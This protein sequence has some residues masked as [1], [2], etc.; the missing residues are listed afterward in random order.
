MYEDAFWRPDFDSVQSSV[1]STAPVA[2]P[3]GSKLNPQLYEQDFMR[4]NFTGVEGDVQSTAARPARPWR[5]YA[6]DR[7]LQSGATSLDMI[8]GLTRLTEKSIK[9]PGRLA[10]LLASGKFDKSKP[11]DEQLMLAA[12]ED[13][14]WDAFA[15]TASEYATNARSWL[16]PQEQR[17]TREQSEAIEQGVGPLIDFVAENPQRV[18]ELVLDNVGYF[19]AGG[20]TAATMRAL[21]AGATLATGGAYATE[22]ALAA[23]AAADQARQQIEQI[24]EEALEQKAPDYKRLR[25]EYGAYQARRILSERAADAASGVAA[26]LNAV[27]LGAT[28]RL[29]TLERYAAGALKPAKTVTGGV[30]KGGIGEFVQEGAQGAGDQFAG[31]AAQSTVFPDTDLT[32]GVGASALLEGLVGAGPGAIAGGLSVIADGKPRYTRPGAVQAAQRR[33]GGA[34]VPTPVVETADPAVNAGASVVSDA[35]NRANGAVA[36][37][38]STAAAPARPPGVSDSATPDAAATIQPETAADI[39][40]LEPLSNRRQRRKAAAQAT[41]PVVNIPLPNVNFDSI[42]DQDERETEIVLA[43]AARNRYIS[44]LQT[45]AEQGRPLT[46]DLVAST[47]ESVAAEIGVDPAILATPETIDA[48]SQRTVTRPEVTPSTQPTGAQQDAVA[49]AQQVAETDAGQRGVSERAG[50]ASVP[51]GDRVAEVAA[52]GVDGQPEAVGLRPD[53]REAVGERPVPPAAPEADVQP[54]SAA[55]APVAASAQDRISALTTEQVIDAIENSELRRQK[56]YKRASIAETRRLLALEPP[57]V[58]ERVLSVVQQGTGQATGE[59]AD[60]TIEDVESKALWDAYRQSTESRLNPWQ[61]KNVIEK[62]ASGEKLKS[63]EQQ[64]IDFA[65]QFTGKGPATQTTGTPKFSRRV[66]EQAQSTR[67]RRL[68]AVRIA[69]PQGDMAKRLIPVTAVVAG[70]KQRVSVAADRVLDYAQKRI[71]NLRSLFDCVS[72]P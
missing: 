41:Q 49:E 71:D 54:A 53:D 60:V 13:S 27:T 16:S 2:K 20:G 65:R 35:I 22:V 30:V 6:K 3:V 24:P 7:A 26:V 43:T 59:T 4:P 70:K 64:F 32:K 8:S 56:R 23:S 12:K 40:Q 52:E 10:S 42:E 48:I 46:P 58:L 9:T 17:I 69:V 11:L 63:K 68:D 61:A 67:Q 66:G 15:D 47:A 14:F 1:S 33:F 62:V 44:L 18:P 21:G 25:Q 51:G 5:E 34:A 28:A 50:V 55:E 38:S 72:A 37:P 39:P 31:N 29:G 36:A 19:A 57:E 45:A